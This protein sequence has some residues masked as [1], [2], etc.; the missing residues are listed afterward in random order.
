MKFLVD[1][2]VLSEW[3]RK[4]PNERV[5]EWL[6]SLNAEDVWISILTVGE[7]RK[8]ILRLPKSR[9]R[10]SFVVWLDE[11]IEAY[12]PRILPVAFDEIE[13][14]AE[15]TAAS[16]ARGCPVSVVDGLLAA[17]ASANQL[18]FATRNIQDVVSMRVPLFNPWTGE[19][20]NA[21]GSDRR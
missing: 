21:D 1:T 19:L 4:T 10:S 3:K 6:S 14:W 5:L 15:L 12:R 9:R 7:L 11:L 17:T 18:V 20:L 13:R 2:C 8:G 16:E